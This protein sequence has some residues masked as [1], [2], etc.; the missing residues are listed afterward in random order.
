MQTTDG[1]NEYPV[2]TISSASGVQAAPNLQCATHRRAN[3][4]IGRYVDGLL[5][6]RPGLER[7]L[8]FA[9]IAGIDPLVLSANRTT[10]SRNGVTFDDYAYDALLDDVTMRER[11]NATND[12]LEPACARPNPNAPADPRPRASCPS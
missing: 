10:R 11:A 1:S 3:H 12:N 8:I 7:R 5:A 4:P 2:P 9:T 6:L